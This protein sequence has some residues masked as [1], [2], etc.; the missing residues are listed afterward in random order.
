VGGGGT[1]CPEWKSLQGKP[2]SCFTFGDRCQKGFRKIIT[3]VDFFCGIVYCFS[4]SLMF[5]CL[6][7]QMKPKFYRI[8]SM[9][10][11]YDP[12]GGFYESQQKVVD[13]LERFWGVIVLD[14]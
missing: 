11:Y 5:L 1:A 3:F 7:S 12:N 2:P 13:F 6:F 10:Y 14:T 9:Q 4:L 8:L